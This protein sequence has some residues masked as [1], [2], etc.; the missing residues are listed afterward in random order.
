MSQKYET[1]TDLMTDGKL[2]RAIEYFENEP[3]YGLYPKDAL[4]RKG[5]YQA[6]PVLYV[7]PTLELGYRMPIAPR[8]EMRFGGYAEYALPIGL[9][10]EMALTDYTDVITTPLVQS[11][12][13][14][15]ESLRLN[16][17]LDYGG[18]SND[19]WNWSRLTVGFR[20]TILFDVT[21]HHCYTCDEDTGV[22]YVQPAKIR[23]M[24]RTQRNVSASAKRSGKSKPNKLEKADMHFGE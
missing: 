10:H 16:S 12:E 18:L 17:I 19:I 8:V 15:W 22:G 21:I 3:V 20:W 24:G 11:K 9:K 1:N 2:D 14:L 4:T 7:S 5:E 6:K 13:Q 23:R